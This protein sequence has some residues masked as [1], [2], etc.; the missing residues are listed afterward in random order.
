MSTAARLGQV[1]APFLWKGTELDVFDSIFE[2][3]VVVNPNLLDVQAG[4]MRLPETD[5]PDSWF[6][7]PE[8]ST[9][10]QISWFWAAAD[11]MKAMFKRFPLVGASHGLAVSLPI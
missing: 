1:R 4:S 8:F 7:A 5:V 3:E 6:H 10:S 9:D 11:D 2:D